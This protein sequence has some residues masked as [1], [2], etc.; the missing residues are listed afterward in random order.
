MFII[1]F[2]AISGLNDADYDLEDEKFSKM[3]YGHD[4][5]SQTKPND[6]VFEQNGQKKINSS[7][8]SGMLLLNL[9]F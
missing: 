2:T 1:I 8:Q 6:S 3:K 5:R 4:S 9:F 7:I